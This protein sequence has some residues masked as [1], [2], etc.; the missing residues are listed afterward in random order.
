[1]SVALTH[2]VSHGQ[3]GGEITPNMTMVA[4]SISVTMG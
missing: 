1:M 4:I 3:Q 2:L